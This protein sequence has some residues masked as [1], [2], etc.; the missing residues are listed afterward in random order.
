MRCAMQA[1]RK[2][3]PTRCQLCRKHSAKEKPNEYLTPQYLNS[4]YSPLKRKRFSVFGNSMLITRDVRPS[5]FL[6]IFAIRTGKLLNMKRNFCTLFCIFLS[7]FFFLFFFFKQLN[8]SIIKYVKYILPG[9]FILPGTA[10]QMDSL[11]NKTT[12]TM[13]FTVSSVPV[14]PYKYLVD[15]RG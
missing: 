8:C 7:C 11:P 6:F 3:D 12:G 15:Q 2:H 13:R 5:L 14:Q 4:Y 1:T 9:T 10:D